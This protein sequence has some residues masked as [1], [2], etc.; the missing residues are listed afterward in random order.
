MLFEYVTLQKDIF[1][2]STLWLPSYHTFTSQTESHS[3]VNPTLSCLSQPH[4]IL[5]VNPNPDDQTK[6]PRTSA[7]AFLSRRVLTL[8]GHG[9][10]SAAGLYEVAGPVQNAFTPDYES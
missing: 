7:P 3:A 2:A 5:T 1:P 8:T 6:S 4:S 10:T 9:A